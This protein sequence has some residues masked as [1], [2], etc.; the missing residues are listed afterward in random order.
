MNNR[1][2]RLTAAQDLLDLLKD[3]IEVARRMAENIG[4]EGIIEYRDDVWNEFN[5]R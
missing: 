2:A 1:D 4:N 3:K 5:K